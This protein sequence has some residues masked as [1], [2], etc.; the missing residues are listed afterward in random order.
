MTRANKHRKKKKISK[1]IPILLIVLILFV[2]GIV[3]FKLKGNTTGSSSPVSTSTNNTAAENNTAGTDN[4]ATNAAASTSESSTNAA[5]TANKSNTSNKTGNS[6]NS[7]ASNTA[8]N[9][10]ANTTQTDT[11]NA[12]SNGNAISVAKAKSILEAK[13]NKSDQKLSV[14]Y[15]HLQTRDNQ[16]YY[17]FRASESGGDSQSSNTS[18]WY[19]VNVNSGEAYNWD[20]IDDKLDLIK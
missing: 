19:Y 3:Y 8:V 17:V 1:F 2:L 14:S 5:N 4:S 16:K 10:A 20:L 13:I 18:G 12:D 11:S 6:V 15:D 9:N 7:T